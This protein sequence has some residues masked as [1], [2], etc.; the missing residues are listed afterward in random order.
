MVPEVLLGVYRNPLK[1]V[2]SVA[3]NSIVLCDMVYE[4]RWV[5]QRRNENKRNRRNRGAIVDVHSSEKS[6]LN[7]VC[8]L[9]RSKGFILTT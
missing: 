7:S 1:I 6:A 4:E 8:R 9:S 5:Q 3:V 2:P